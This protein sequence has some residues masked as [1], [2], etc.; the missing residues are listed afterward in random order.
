VKASRLHLIVGLILGI[1]VGVGVLA[2][3]FERQVNASYEAEITMQQTLSAVRKLE[4]CLRSM[5]ADQG[6]VTSLLQN[7]TQARAEFDRCLNRLVD[8]QEGIP[9]QRDSRRRM[10]ETWRRIEEFDR[11]I[12][13]LFGDL[14]AMGHLEVAANIGLVI[15]Q[16][17]IVEQGQGQDVELGDLSLLLYD[18]ELTTLLVNEVEN[19]LQLVQAD[20]RQR[21]VAK[22]GLLQYAGVATIVVAVIL[23]GYL[24]IRLARLYAAVQED[25]RARMAAEAQALA[26][27][28]DLRGILDSIGEA[29]ISTDATGRV[30]RMNPAAEA[31]LLLP[32][33][34]ASGR[35]AGS[36]CMLGGGAARRVPQDPVSDVLRSGKPLAAGEVLALTRRDGSERLVSMIAG[37]IHHEAGQ[38][39]GVVMALRDV[40]EQQRM[41]EQLR[42]S[43]RLDSIGQLAGGV[44]H[45]INNF[46]QVVHA[47]LDLLGIEGGLSEEGRSC[48]SQISESANRTANLIRQLLAFGRR[49]N[50]QMRQVDV[51]ELVRNILVL[52]RRVIGEN[53]AVRFEP[54]ERKAWVM[55]DPGQLEQVVVNLCVNARD[56]MPKGGHIEIGLDFLDFSEERLRSYPWAKPGE[57]LL[58]AVIDNGHGISP[59]ILASIFEPFFTTKP[60][61][62]GTG[63]GLS[64]VQG[65]VQQH[66]GFIQVSSQP[67]YGSLFGV[68]LPLIAEPAARVEE[69]REVPPNVSLQGRGRLVLVAE[70]E[71]AVR[72][73]TQQMLVRMGYRVVEASDGL[74][75]I[76]LVEQHVEELAVVLLDVIMPR[77]GGLEAAKRIR[78]IRPDLPL[79]FSTGYSD[80]R[81]LQ[82]ELPGEKGVVLSKPYSTVELAACLAK[83]IP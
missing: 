75:A 32:R 43:Q 37:P 10:A 82:G 18:L 31:L 56:A 13:G 50:L 61:G 35:L 70:D 51:V 25:N 44:A 48:V 59:E 83:L 71:V 3:V 6:S 24:L 77:M 15:H 47:N 64:V 40:S 39:V 74:Q 30:L 7:W 5:K 20:L 57:Y 60:Q 1:L 33:S 54:G 28:R 46:L 53:I 45:D 66:G 36:L 34:E 27:E 19:E 22:L 23:V 38:L 17:R 26:S 2:V 58:L 14:R 29:V 16:R 8:L 65:I 41:E 55:A 12:D 72:Q 80:G 11:E 79:V 62:R 69:R 73:A 76:E 68:H 81:E 4:V 49:Q 78:R 9:F 52:L 42:R 21:T 63:L 67:G